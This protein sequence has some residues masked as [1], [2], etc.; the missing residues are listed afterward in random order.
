MGSASPPSLFLGFIPP[1]TA[2]LLLAALGILVHI[3]FY[4]YLGGVRQALPVV[5]DRPYALVAPVEPLATPPPHLAIASSASSVSV[6]E[7]FAE[8]K[9]YL[10]AQGV[11]LP[12]DGA[13]AWK[14]ESL[15]LLPASQAVAGEVGAPKAEAEAGT[16][17]EA[18]ALRS[19]TSSP[20]SFIPSRQ[21]SL[22]SSPD[23]DADAAAAAAAVAPPPHAYAYT[24][25][26]DT[27]AEALERLNLHSLRVVLT[28][29]RLY[30]LLNLV[31]CICGVLGVLLSHLLLSRLFVVHYFVDLLLTTLSLFALAFIST[32][33]SIQR[34][35]CDEHLS[36][37]LALFPPASPPPPPTSA[38]KEQGSGWEALVETLFTA[39]NCQESWTTTL[40]PLCLLVAFLY[41]AI[42]I[43]AFLVV[44]RFYTGLLRSKLGAGGFNDER[45]L[46]FE[47]RRG[48]GKEAKSLE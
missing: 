22:L 11:A 31:C 48:R 17:L 16:T 20:S 9:A 46:G 42:K 14:M 36:E 30:T 29:L 25:L 6:P 15:R 34:Q 26:A 18:A 35:I 3:N 27:G 47:Y 44:Q 28:S 13:Q 21:G 43:H 19:G 33:P 1:R 40:V 2:T 32:Y 5:P 7:W 38:G 41:T 10:K 37:P 8:A 39:E 45:A 12:I 23:S 24:P 4:T